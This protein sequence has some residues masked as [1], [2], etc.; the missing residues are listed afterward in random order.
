[1]LVVTLYAMTTACSPSEP[2]SHPERSTSVPA[3]L[4]SRSAASTASTDLRQFANP[5]YADD[6]PDPAAILVD[7]IYYAYATQGN[8]RN[9][10]TL[11]SPDLV[12]WVPGADA[13]PQLG[14]WAQTGDTWAPEVIAD[15]GR[16]VMFYVA[17]D[18]A[19]GV[20]CIGRAQAPHPTGPFVDSSDR[21]FLCQP[22]IGGSIDPNPV[23]DS[24]G[25]LYLY[26][27]NDGNCCG[28]PVGVWGVQLDHDAEAAVGDPVRLLTNTK[29]W[30][31]D[32]IEAPEM[33]EHGATHVL[34]YSANGFSG[35]AY[36]MGY[37][38]C[39]SALGP[40][41]DRSDTPL[42]ATTTDAAGPGHCF[43]LTTSGG[44]TWMLFHAWRPDAIGSVYP[45]RELWL[46]PV[47]WNGTAPSLAPPTS[48]WITVP[49]KP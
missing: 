20:Q 40:C 1:M 45:G 31:G 37:A 28:D 43:V 9:I 10:Q 8:G 19:S 17:R 13:L 24:D 7:S 44:G 5:V 22:E 46:E 3:G 14:A 25:N 26:W 32:L 49:P 2:K 21:P 4:S 27:K 30:Q 15:S 42:M 12:H 29:P 38:T 23:K 48:E 35:D 41:T 36:A 47:H 33:Y 34:F 6:F 39:T 11:T 18:A 16:Y